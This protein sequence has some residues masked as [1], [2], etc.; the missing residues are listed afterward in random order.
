MPLAGRAVRDQRRVQRQDD[1]GQVTCRVRMRE[2]AAE[3]APVPD[4]GVSHGARG[5]RQQAAVLRDQRVVHHPVMRSP[6]T[7]QQMV[8][9]VSY[10]AEL[11]Q[12]ADVY[13]QFRIG[14]PEP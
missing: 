6:G 14:Q 5:L 10:T 8:A 2:R 11:V 1:G 4:R 13:Q 7:D 12:A 3:R 9:A